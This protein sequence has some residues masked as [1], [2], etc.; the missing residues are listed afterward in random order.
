MKCYTEGAVVAILDHGFRLDT[1][2]GV[3]QVVTTQAAGSEL[4]LDV[5][6]QVTVEGG[7]RDDGTFAGSSAR[8]RLPS[9]KVVAIEINRCGP[10]ARTVQLEGY[11][12]GQ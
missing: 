2:G 3:T 9:G 8:K 6:D 12:R 1:G 10:W 4:D 11:G 7:P 5:G